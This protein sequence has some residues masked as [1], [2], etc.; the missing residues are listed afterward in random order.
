MSSKK[1]FYKHAKKKEDELNAELQKGEKISA[2]EYFAM[3]SSAFIVI[4][5]ICAALLIALG[6]LVLWIFGAI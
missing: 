3:I 1:E 4:F 6:A 5:P 2:K